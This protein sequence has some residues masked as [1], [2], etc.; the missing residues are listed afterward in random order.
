MQIKFYQSLN[1]TYVNEAI[2][3]DFYAV[4]SVAKLN[5]A[6]SI[7]INISHFNIN[8]N[9]RSVKLLET[10]STKQIGQQKRFWKIN[11]L[12]TD[13]ETRSKL[14]WKIVSNN[15]KICVSQGVLA[16]AYYIVKSSS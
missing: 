12:I 14:A 6:M 8:K 11:A 4:H 9:T 10:N 15:V 16:L 13:E 3:K 2:L 7:Q 1:N 5:H